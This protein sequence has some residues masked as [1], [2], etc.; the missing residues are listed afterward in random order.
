MAKQQSGSRTEYGTYEGTEALADISKEALDA[1]FHA[2]QAKEEAP[3]TLAERRAMLAAQIVD[4]ESRLA[5][6]KEPEF[7]RI[8]ADVESANRIFGT[9][10]AL[11]D[12]AVKLE[13]AARAPRKCGICR[14]VGHFRKSCPKVATA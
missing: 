11:V 8:T 7:Q 12:Q 2:K 14:E 1:A 13:P 10:W 6:G 4:I 3:S 5:A 9:S